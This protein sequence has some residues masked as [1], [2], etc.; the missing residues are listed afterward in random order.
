MSRDKKILYTSSTALVLV[1]LGALFL[2]GNIGYILTAL[3]LVVAA[4]AIYFLVKKRPILSINKNT[5]LL[6]M[7]A[8][9]AVCL[10]LYYLTGVHFGFYK[11]STPLS[12]RSFFKNILPISTIIIAIEFIRYVFLAQ[13]A[14]FIG[15][16][17][18]IIGIL[19]EL[20]VFST[21]ESITTFSRFMDAMGLYLLPAVTA[22]ILYNF[23]AKN[24]GFLPGIAYRLL[25]T[26][27]IHVLPVYPQTPDVLFSFAKLLFP[28]F[29][30]AFLNALYTKTKRYEKP[31]TKVAE[32]ISMGLAALFMISIVVLISGAFR[33]RTI[34]I[35]T[36][37]MTGSLNKGD[38]IIYKEYD[39]HYV[40]E[41]D[42]LVFLQDGRR[43]V[44]RVIEIERI[45]GTNRYYTKGDA[46]SDM[47]PDYITDADIEGV[48][49]FKIPY[50]GYLSLW[51]RE[52]FKK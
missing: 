2:P 1:L 49:L 10:V 18:Y 22:N 42:I 35:A 27:Y 29:I 12:V 33:Y 11:S 3:L 9:G 41:Q 20:L 40:Q 14:R 13:N 28:L 38:A 19:S 4:I 16:L 46:N 17:S 51:M 21:L 32:W 31:R 36:E 43:I 34:I 48:V 25:M 52:A 26:L 50:F 7:I 30:Y 23:L 5:V 44:H 15:I 8:V 45:N 39:N 24:Y 47:D 6:I 37:S